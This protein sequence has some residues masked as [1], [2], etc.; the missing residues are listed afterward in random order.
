MINDNLENKFLH[1]KF[2]MKLKILKLLKTKNMN[3]KKNDEKVFIYDTNFVS[4][5]QSKK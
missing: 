1:L 4:K 2:S 5:L 3:Y